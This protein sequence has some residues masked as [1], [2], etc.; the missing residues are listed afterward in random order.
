MKTIR[1]TENIQEIKYLLEDYYDAL[2]YDGSPSFNDF[3]PDTYNSVWFILLEN[4]KPAGLIKL[5]S[6]NYTL[7]IPHIII[8]K[9]YRGN[10]SEEWG[11]QV[12][13][14]M[15]ERLK[16]AK[17]LAL[18]PYESAKQYAERIG[19]KYISTLCGSIKKNG[20]LMNQYMLE[21]S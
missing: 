4:E 5:E 6:L 11:L 20:K 8:Y 9:K 10:G 7:F 18:T 12:I 21:M 16:D 15:K 19:F 13:E 2:V 3:V 17:F 14:Y 1:Q